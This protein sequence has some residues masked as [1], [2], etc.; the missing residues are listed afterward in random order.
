MAGG[1]LTTRY[2]LSIFIEFAHANYS[3]FDPVDVA[4]Q[5]VVVRLSDPTKLELTHHPGAKLADLH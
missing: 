4:K 5:R 2:L 3:G 1:S